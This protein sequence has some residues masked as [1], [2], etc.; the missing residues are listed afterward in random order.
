MPEQELKGIIGFAGARYFPVTTNTE[1]AYATGGMKMFVGAVGGSRKDNVKDYHFAGDDSTYAQGSKIDT[2]DIVIEVS[3]LSLEDEAALVGSAYVTTDG[4]YSF[5]D[6]KAPT[7][8]IGFA[9]LMLN[10][11]YR[12]VLYPCAKLIG[13]END[14]KTKDPNGNLEL[15][16]QKLT[17]RCERRKADKN[18]YL[19]R[20]SK[21]KTF[22]WLNAIEQIAE[23]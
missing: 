16:T 22:G 6:M 23:G 13:I 4:G 8:A 5:S 15:K 7:V 11:E 20:D 9:T 18:L 12:M 14:I 10:D 19:K 17:F 1:A 3:E 2:T 21:D